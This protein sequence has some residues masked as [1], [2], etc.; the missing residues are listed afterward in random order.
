MDGLFIEIGPLKMVNDRI[1]G[2]PHSWHKHANLLFVDQPVGTGFSYTGKHKYA[3]S[4]EEVADQFYTFLVEFLELHSSLLSSD[5]S[6][7]HS[8]A[9]H[10]SGTY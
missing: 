6:A 8:R 9:I 5:G 10:F 2:N 1:Q 4:N 3:S 7:R